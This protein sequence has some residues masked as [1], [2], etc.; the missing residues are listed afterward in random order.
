[1]RDCSF[2]L[3]TAQTRQGKKK[4]QELSKQY[5][6]LIEE[7]TTLKQKIRK[8]EKSAEG[9]RESGTKYRT[10]IQNIQEGYLETDL[11][12]KW[13]FVNDIIPK[14][15]GYTRRE[16]MEMPNPIG[17]L[18]TEDNA[19]KSYQAFRTI[20]KTGKP[21]KSFEIELIKKDGS[22]GNYEIS[23]SLM[24]DATGKP[25][26]F[27]CISRDIT[28]RK[29]MERALKES[30]KQ[31]R[32]IVE[33]MY[34]SIWTMD[35]DLHF[36]Y[37]SPSEI[38]TSGY[39][40]EEVMQIPVEKLIT[41]ESYNVVKRIFGEEIEREFGEGPV[42]LN[43]KRIIEIELNHKNG[44]TYWQETTAS[45]I[46]D[47]NGKPTGIVCVGRDITAR[48][49]A[50]HD[51]Q[52]ARDHLLQAEKLSAIG[53]LSA[54]V[55]H[56]ILNPVNI[57]ST[58]IQFLQ[59]MENMPHEAQE[60]LQICMSQIDRIV[61][62]A[63]G[64]KHRSSIPEKRM[65]MA[66][67]NDV[68]TDIMTLHKSQLMIDKIET[69]LQYHPDLPEM[70]MD[71]KKIEQVI[72]NLIS[73]ARS[74]MEGKEKKL[75]RISTEWEANHDQV[76]IVV[77]DTGCGIK[78]EH[79]LKIFNPFFTTKE[80]GKGTGLGLSISYGIIKDHGGKIWA[81]NNKW[82]GA[83]FNIIFPVKTSHEPS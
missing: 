3:H 60:E 16:L 22:T 12:G 31:Y 80:Q 47:E 71:R 57:I 7:N 14:L 17:R 55:A 53:Q 41:P 23:V 36:T 2:C 20:Y 62:I 18:Q 6:K 79:M 74:A 81:K 19:K 61:A 69:D 39:T 66:N 49:Q 8:L 59:T 82:G 56:E 38:H 24:K 26:G 30:E 75:L 68:I 25:V 43:R 4:M 83:T 54:G 50:E 28:E 51:L 70:L 21:L 44:G 76:R 58:E 67:I 78:S 64:L 15:L 63:D 40:P 11:T 72:L 73:N 48:K 13:I 34:D 35:M 33:N 45:F 29:V 1:M 5:H 42:D 10:I 52:T 37:L 9:L 27:R 77:A 65:E 46:R 32:M